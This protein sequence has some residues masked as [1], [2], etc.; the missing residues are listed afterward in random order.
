MRAREEEA[1]HFNWCINNGLKIYPI[2]Y[3][4]GLQLV[5]AKMV[6]KKWVETR[7]KEWFSST[8]TQKDQK[9]WEKMDKLYKHY[10][11]LGNDKEYKNKFKTCQ[12]K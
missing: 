2:T 8:P 6:K 9:W 3:S 5:V 11:K 1:K 10:Y 12:K 7:G 4:S